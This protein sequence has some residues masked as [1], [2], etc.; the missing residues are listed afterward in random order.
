MSQPEKVWVARYVVTLCDP[1]VDLD[2]RTET[3]NAVTALAGSDPHWLAAWAAGL[4]SDIVRSLD[5]ED[6]WRKLSLSE[7][8]ALHPDGSP[9]GSYVDATDMVHPNTDDLRSDLGLAALEKRLTPDAASLVAVAN[10]G[11]SKTLDWIRANLIVDTVLPPEEAKKFFST[12]HS[13][14]R[15][16]I[17]RRRLFVGFDDHFVPVSGVEWT[18]RAYKILNGESWDEARAARFLQQSAVPAGSYAQF[19]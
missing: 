13:A 3:E 17:Y 15:W 16:A 4:L 14:L 2:N 9:F 1:L 6:P 19:T 11:W 7:H 5:P 10:Q 12:I 18:N 8:G